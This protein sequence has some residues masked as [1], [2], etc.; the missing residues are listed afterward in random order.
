M[1]M[2]RMVWLRGAFRTYPNVP[3]ANYLVQICLKGSGHTLLRMPSISSIVALPPHSKI[4]PH[5]KPGR[6]NVQISN[7]YVHLVKQDTYISHQKP[8]KNGLKNPAHAVY[9][10]TQH[11][12][13]TINYGTQPDM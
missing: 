11:D 3:C 12:Q 13:R 5:L 4:R 1:N 2:N 6:E 8:E 7:I 9:S 10:D